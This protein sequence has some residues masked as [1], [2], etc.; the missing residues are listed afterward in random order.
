MRRDPAISLR[1]ALQ[2][3]GHH[4]RPWLERLNGVLGGV[5]LAAGPIP[6][7][8]GALWGW[9]DQKN[10]ATALLRSVLDGVSDRIRPSYGLARHELVVAAHSTIVL[11]AFFDALRQDLGDTYDE[12]LITEA[13]KVSI[14]TGA[15]RTTT[16]PLVRRLY[17]SEL[18]A[19]SALRGFEE[20]VENVQFWCLKTAAEVRKFLGG[21]H[22][23]QPRTFD[24]AAVAL[25]GAAGYRSL[26]L[27]LATTVPEFGMWANLGEH[28]ATR[29]AM[30]RLEDLL[31]VASVPSRDLREVVRDTN[32]A[33]LGLPVIDVG[34]DGY[35]TGTVFPAVQDI[36]VTPRFRVAEA[37]P[38][39]TLSGERWWADLAIHED[40][41]LVLARHFS[42]G[43]STRL[44]LLLLGHPG[45]G[46]SLLVKVLAAR[47]P[48]EGYTVVR[49]PLRSVEANGVITRQ[50][51][52]ALDLSTHQRVRWPDLVDQS[53]DTIR[54]VLLDGLDE[55]LQATTHD[56][57]GYLQEVAEFQR[58]EA[59]MGRPVAV[60]VTSRTLVIDR[61]AVPEGTPVVKLEEFDR[62]QIRQWVAVWNDHNRPMP[63][64]FALNYP[65]LA[66]QPLLLLMLALYYADS[67]APVVGNLSKA[68][69]YERLLD[70]YARREV[71][72]KAGRTL[73]G[74]EAESALEEQLRRLST[75]ALGMFNRG[76]QDIT[77]ADLG[78]DLE[79]LGEPAD[80]DRV[81]GEFFFVHAAEARVGSV[82]RCY[83]FLHAT[84]GEYLVAAR[85][86]EVLRDV[87]EGAF[88]RR[89]EH[90]PED[91]L[92]FALLSHQPLAIQ[93]PILGFIGERL[94]ALD[95]AERDQVVRT[96]D[97]LVGT[98]RS[99][100]PSRDFGQYRPLPF[101]AVRVLAAYSANLVL[102]RL[103]VG[104]S[105]PLVTLWPENALGQWQSTVSLWESG[106]DA[107]GYQTMLASLSYSEGVL[108][109][110]GELFSLSVP[111]VEVQ[112]AR[113]R[114]EQELERRLRTGLAIHDQLH[115]LADPE[116]DELRAEDWLHYTEGWL[117]AAFF[118][119]NGYMNYLY[120]EIPS[121]VSVDARRAVS[122]TAHGLLE[123]SWGRWPNGFI[124]KFVAWLVRLSDLRDEAVLRRTA[125]LCRSELPLWL[126]HAMSEDAE[127]PRDAAEQWLLNR[128]GTFGQWRPSDVVV[129][130][131]V[132]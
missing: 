67:P 131:E 126:S 84:F 54:V 17:T 6:A 56:R 125:E 100:K 108:H 95:Q 87:A 28:A 88:G 130:A 40:L 93:W 21:L 111:P 79:S 15:W 76:R 59:V 32:R 9:V 115:Y 64:E 33:V 29:S 20:N 69:L 127:S 14:G 122:V 68:E 118:A 25:A 121:G 73:H 34:T 92:L 124:M 102:L 60:V 90:D 113:I 94:K 98:Y 77:E 86:V 26:Y 24:P 112:R 72:K 3:L 116:L 55:L 66:G 91:D 103:W 47:L 65:D 42:T 10:E 132:E 96:L 19:P 114:G 36:F 44:P 120:L 22:L 57:A 43:L 27:A 38:Q 23:A 35:G 62:D 74:R 78:A 99:R 70:T 97:L 105:V 75:A 71:T 123:K 41:D 89:R 48:D 63:A 18:P 51:Q 119:G 5:I 53:T 129:V 2:I 107:Q 128:P 110:H 7:A 50:I 61:V 1:G 13:E 58:V 12:A 31:S 8:V 81:L 45:A 4:D 37:G 82:R 49:V 11:T 80:G 85:V 39:T 109:A 52:Q 117:M 101:D 46:K 16:E 30:A 106:M 104:S 83:E